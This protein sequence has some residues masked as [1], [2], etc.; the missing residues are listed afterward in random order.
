MY[1]QTHVWHSLTQ[2]TAHTIIPLEIYNDCEKNY[3]QTF[4]TTITATTTQ[5]QQITFFF[6]KDNERGK[7]KCLISQ[8]L[9][10]AYHFY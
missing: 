7:E 4:K 8:F 5:R 2:F 10:G 1:E 3:G 6:A 9:R